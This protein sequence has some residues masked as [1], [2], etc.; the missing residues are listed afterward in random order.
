MRNARDQL[1]KIAR[2]FENVQKRAEHRALQTSWSLK[3]KITLIAENKELNLKTL[4]K[5]IYWM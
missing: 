3:S 5:M 1:D 2:S 4:V